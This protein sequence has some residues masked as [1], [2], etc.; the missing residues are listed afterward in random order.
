MLSF[1]AVRREICRLF[2]NLC[3]T[4]RLSSFGKTAPHTSVFIAYDAKSPG[5]RQSGT[6]FMPFHRFLH[7]CPLCCCFFLAPPYFCRF[8][9][10]PPFCLFLTSPFLFLSV[11][12]LPFPCTAAFLL[13]LATL[14]FCLFLAPPY[15]CFPCVSAFLLFPCDTAFEVFV[16]RNFLGAGKAI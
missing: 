1:L 10:T 4:L 2:L 12:V 5:R 13:S 6:H 9:V 14:P 11:A 16:K 3:G 7:L 8:L 15:L